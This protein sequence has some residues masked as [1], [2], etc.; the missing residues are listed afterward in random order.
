MSECGF[1]IVAVEVGEKKCCEVNHFGAS[2][3]NA[4]ATA[5]SGEPVTLPSVVVFNAPSFFFRLRQYS[6][7]DN[8]GESTPS[9]SKEMTNI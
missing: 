5:K 2:G 8:F 1:W 4:G 6:P 3:H 9:V 7:V